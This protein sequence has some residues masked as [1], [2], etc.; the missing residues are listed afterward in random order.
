MAFDIQGPFHNKD[1]AS[2]KGSR[3]KKR[4]KNLEKR[5]MKEILSMVLDHSEAHQ[6]QWTGMC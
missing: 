4:K 5:P 6:F 3:R 1:R 2:L